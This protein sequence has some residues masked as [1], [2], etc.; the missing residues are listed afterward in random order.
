MHPVC[1]G[2]STSTGLDK[3]SCANF[4]PQ[5]SSDCALRVASHTHTPRHQFAFPPLPTTAHPCSNSNGPARCGC[6][7]PRTSCASST[8]L[9]RPRAGGGPLGHRCPAQA[10]TQSPPHRAG[11]RYV[12]HDCA[13]GMGA[14][15]RHGKPWV[16]LTQRAPALHRRG[17][18]HGDRSHRA[19]RQVHVAATD[20]TSAL[21]RRVPPHH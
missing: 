10:R 19:H 20:Q 21:P 18:G 16:G 4:E 11:P 6:R 12:S 2:R 14:L 15:H 17:A 9:T 5:K 13:R 7:R 8:R 3:S 1:F